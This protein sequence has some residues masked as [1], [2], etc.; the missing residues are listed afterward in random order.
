MNVPLLRETQ[1]RIMADPAH[2]DMDWFL[3]REDEAGYCYAP[4]ELE[5]CGTARCIGGEALLA[6]GAKVRDTGS[7]CGDFVATPEIVS[8]VPD[9][10]M[11]TESEYVVFNCAK[12]AQAV[13][14]LSLD[15]ANRLFYVDMW[16][17]QFSRRYNEAD[18][19]E[20]RSQIAAERI[21]W[22]IDTNGTDDP[23]NQQEE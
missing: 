4:T 14:E 9:G 3:S 1:K 22:F 16:P 6:A 21:D 23:D 15:Q 20:L 10:T 5:P 19:H 2:F 17:S 11:D 8:K 12:A 7:W 18:T 13:L